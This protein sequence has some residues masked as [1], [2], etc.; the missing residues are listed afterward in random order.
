M[1]ISFKSR[2]TKGSYRPHLVHVAG[3]SPRIDNGAALLAHRER[4]PLGSNSRVPQI[5]QR[6]KVKDGKGG[7]KAESRQPKEAEV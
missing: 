7:T 1:F 4:I 2:R 6:E 3:T 5:K